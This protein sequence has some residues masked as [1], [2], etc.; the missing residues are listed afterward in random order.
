MPSTHLEQPVAGEARQR[1]AQNEQNRRG[2][3]VGVREHRDP[4]LDLAPPFDRLVHR[5]LVGVLEVAADRH[6]H[7]DPRDL[8]AERLQQTG[9]V[10]GGR[11]AF[12][13]RV[14]REDDFV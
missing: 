6:A 10:D 12:D 14:G 9:Q 4:S 5:H 13:V 2:K 3:L 8:D 1:A 11:L 7:R